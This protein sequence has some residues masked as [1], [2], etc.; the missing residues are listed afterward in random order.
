MDVRP[1]SPPPRYLFR[2]HNLVRQMRK[3]P[4]VESFLD[5][6]CGA[7]DLACVLSR[8]FGLSGIGIDF[9]EKAI[10]TA[11]KLKDF[12]GLKNSP[13]FKLVDGSIPKDTKKADV[14]ICLEVLEHVKD[15]EK[16][17]K[18]LVSLSNKFVIISV[19][20]KQDL[21]T[22]SDVLAGHYRRY[23]KAELKE[24][25]RRNN[26]HILSFVSYGYP[27]TNLIR[28]GRERVAKKKHTSTKQ[29]KKAGTQKSGYDLLDVNKYFSLPLERFLL[30]L[31]HFSRMFNGLNLSEGYLVICE[32]EN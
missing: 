8:D 26:L 13:V 20:A 19:P 5:V 21:F 10:E 27:F 4:E 3:L 2:R 7:G 24:M 30:P 18:E 25:L 17:L 31:C 12:Y 29:T 14:V 11:N 9:S 22:H 16:L 6:G 32:K 15:D 1:W 28:L 23:E